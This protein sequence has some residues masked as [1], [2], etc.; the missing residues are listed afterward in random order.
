MLFQT[1]LSCFL[2]SETRPPT[3]TLTLTCLELEVNQPIP[4]LVRAKLLAKIIVGLAA[5]PL[6][7]DLDELLVVRDL[8]DEVPQ[9]VRVALKLEVVERLDDVVGD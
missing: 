5:V 9:F 6:V 1:E 8:V 2:L 4:A 7:L 3:P